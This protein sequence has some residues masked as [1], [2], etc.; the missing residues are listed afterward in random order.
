MYFLQ[1]SLVWDKLDKTFLYLFGL[2]LSHQTVHIIA[3]TAWKKSWTATS[4]SA[5][6]LFHSF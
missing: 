5:L 3:T 6:P 1:F 2:V 4:F